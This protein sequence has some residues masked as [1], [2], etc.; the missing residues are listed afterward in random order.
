MRGVLCK[1][2]SSFTTQTKGMVS[3]QPEDGGKD[4]F[5]HVRVLSRAGIDGLREGQRVT[6]EVE[7][8]KRG[9]GMQAADVK[10][11]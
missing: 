2:R 4:V 11:A 6:F 7:P 8:D 10:L 3:S 5:A 1:A 9:R